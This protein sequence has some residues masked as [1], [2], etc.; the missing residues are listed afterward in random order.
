MRQALN[1]TVLGGLIAIALTGASHA[2]TIP[3]LSA[4]RAAPGMPAA[5]QA[6]PIPAGR[7]VY[8]APGDFRWMNDKP[9]VQRATVIGETVSFSI[10]QM[11]GKAPA[12]LTHPAETVLQGQG[13]RVALDNTPA[14]VGRLDVAVVAPG[15]QSTVRVSGNEAAQFLVFTATPVAPGMVDASGA[16]P[17]RVSSTRINVRVFDT[18]PWIGE[19]GKSRFKAIAGD[20][21]TFVIWRIPAA[22]MRGTGGPGHHHTIEQISYLVEGHSTTRIGDQIRTVGPGALFMIPADVDHMGFEAVNNEDIIL[23]DFQPFIRKDLLSQQAAK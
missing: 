6:V 18:M 2:Q 1:L 20:S 8:Y 13:G 19:K 21:C 10:V 11:D 17:Q 5:P 16:N 23:L 7:Q 22:A 15:P 14:P 9:H 12:A 3:P 4:S